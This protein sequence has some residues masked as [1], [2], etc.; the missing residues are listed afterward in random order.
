MKNILKV[1]FVTFI[2]SSFFSCDKDKDIITQDTTKE[3]IVTSAAG[4]NSFGVT[5]PGE[6]KVSIDEDLQEIGRAHV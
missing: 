5:T 4:V 3:I 6:W 2:I 1:F